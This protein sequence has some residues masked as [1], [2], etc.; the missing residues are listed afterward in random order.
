M[1]LNRQCFLY[2]VC[3]DAFYEPEEQEIHK[4]LLKLYSLRKLLKDSKLMA[5]N[6]IANDYDFWKKSV[7]ILIKAEKDRLSEILDRRLDDRT[8]RVLNPDALKD[9]AIISLFESSLTRALGIGQNELTQDLFILNVFFFQIFESLVKDGFIYNGNKYVFLTAS[10]GQIRTKRAVFIREDR[11]DVIQQK[12]MCGLTVEEINNRGGINTNKYL[13]YLALCNSATDVWE[14]FDIDRSIVVDDFETDVAGEVDYINEIDYSITRQQAN[15]PIPHTD[16]CGMMLNDTTRMVRLPWVKGLLVTFPFDKFIQEKCNGECKI[17]DIY[18]NEHDIIAENIK[19]IFT[20][21]QFKLWKFYD[22]WDCYKAQFKAWQ[23]EA[24]YCNIEEPFI[25]KAKIN[26]QM[27]QT[28]S[29]IKDD[30]IERITRRTVD[31]INKVGNDYQTT[32]RLL[33]ATD[34]NQSPNYFQQALMLYPELFRDAYHRDILKQVKKSLVKQAKGG[35]LVVNGRYQFLAPDLYAFCEWLFLGIQN[36]DGLLADGEVYSRLNRDGAELACL[37]S[38]HL[39]REWAV[40]K[41]KRGEELDKWFGCTKCVYTSTHDLISRY[42]MFDVDGDKSLVI[43]DRTLTAIAKRNMR[44]IRPLAYE[45]KKAKGGLI[46]PEALYEGMSHAYTGGN[47]G[48]I[49]NNITKV[50]NSGNIGEEQ[51]NVVKWL[52]L[53]NNAVID[54]AKTLWL[55]EPPKDINKKIKS[56]TKAKVPHFFIYAKDKE[57]A[58]CESVND[59]TMNRISNVIPNPMVRY[60]KNLRQFDYQMLMNHDADFTIRRSPILDSYD[61]WL[62]HKYEFYDPNESIDDEDLYMYQ[63]IREKILELGDKDYVVNSLV[64]YCYT[65]KK[66]SNKKLLWACFGKEIVENIKRN[67]P[68]L[69]EKQGKVCPI[70]GRRF[71]PRAQGNSKYC[72]DECLNLANKQ[73]SYA[74]WENG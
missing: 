8:P 12:I 65:V 29:D 31:E 56:Y 63:Q 45:L 28:L 61:Y 16:G 44:D 26:Y 22:S 40:R 25:P 15:T 6:E 33:G 53:Y 11:Y 67:L 57:S 5:K 55:P 3:T 35:R 42:L 64:A 30:E 50:W 32:M 48:P 41:N 38:P 2:S 66:T 21:S 24:C 49:S 17:Y 7:N 69:E 74:R 72:S 68:E 34:Y 9:K 58:Q 60:N 54:Y 47:I 23:C 43:Q 71:K 27:L 36:P 20:K 62:R 73:A 51:L 4:R 37:R 14:D 39:Y 70:C 1:S 52:C 59:S 10:A 46:T 19:Y 13:A 18:G